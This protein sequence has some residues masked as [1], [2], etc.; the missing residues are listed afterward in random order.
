MRQVAQQPDAQT[1]VQ[2]PAE[3]EVSNQVAVFGAGGSAGSEPPSGETPH[4]GR[5]LSFDGATSVQVAKADVFDM[6]HKDF[7]GWL[8]ATVERNPNHDVAII[9]RTG[10]RTGRIMQAL[11][12]NKVAGVLD[13]SE[14]MVGGSR[15][16]GWIPSGLPVVPAQQAY[17]AMPRD[18][19][20]T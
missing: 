14:G 10:N 8:M 4:A 11:A 1:G 2:L 20:K 16:K 5:R 15:G 17:D 6:T 13:V 7:G 3:E 19:T 18:L 9:C 12:R